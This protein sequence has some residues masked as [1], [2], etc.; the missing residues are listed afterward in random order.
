M[1]EQKRETLPPRRLCAT[2]S[3]EHFGIH[4]TASA[5]RASVREAITEVFL[6]C[7]KQSTPLDNSCRDSAVAISL[8]LQYGCP[9]SVLAHAMAREPSGA[10]STPLGTLLDILMKE[11]QA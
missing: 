3:F 8:A 7:D 1:N 4:F 2:Y 9:L 6:N 11:E 10:P 5:G